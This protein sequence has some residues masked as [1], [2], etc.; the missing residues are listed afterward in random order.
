[1]SATDTELV[2]YYGEDEVRVRVPFDPDNF[3]LESIDALQTGVRAELEKKRPK[4]HTGEQ[5]QELRFKEPICETDESNQNSFSLNPLPKLCELGKIRETGE[6]EHPPEEPVD[7]QHYTRMLCDDIGGAN[8]YSCTVKVDAKDWGVLLPVVIQN[9]SDCQDAFDWRSQRD[10]II[11]WKKEDVERKF[12]DI[13]KYS[14]LP[15][16]SLLAHETGPLKFLNDAGIRSLIVQRLS[17]SQ[18]LGCE[19]WYLFAVLGKDGSASPFSNQNQI[20]LHERTSSIQ[21]QFEQ[22]LDEIPEIAKELRENKID[23]YD[24]MV[25]APYA[26][27]ITGNLRRIAD[28]FGW[29][30]APF[31][32]EYFPSPSPKSAD[33]LNVFDKYVLPFMQAYEQAIQKPSPEND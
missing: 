25:G 30:I 21:K 26:R 17:L 31:L 19:H 28:Y 4:S 1:M 8:L 18:D 6:I 3:N 24:P 7:I 9:N 32:R 2:V 5:I 22:R 15:D 10:C 16:N 12:A 14:G 29:N 11:Q 27:Q 13:P 33:R 20:T 23:I